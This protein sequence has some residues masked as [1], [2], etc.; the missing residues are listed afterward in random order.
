MDKEREGGQGAQQRHPELPA[1][2]GPAWQLC[3]GVFS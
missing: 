1:F 3:L 2:L